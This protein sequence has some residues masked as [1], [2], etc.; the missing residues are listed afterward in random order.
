MQTRKEFIIQFVGL[1]A[2]EHLYEYDID[3]KFFEDRDYSE[4]TESDLQVK[5]YLLKQSSMM[6]L[7]FEISGTVKA[8]CDRCTADFDLPISGNYKLI[9]KVGGSDTGNEDDD[10]ITVPANE[11]QLDISQYLYEYIALSLPI[12]RIHPEDSEGEPTCDKEMLKKLNDFLIE[13]EKE[14]P[15]D[16]RWDGLKDISLN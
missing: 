3:G 9:V 6:V 8:V 12:K 5:L 15:S 14:E 16:P 11:H 13:E 10:I 7:R 4:I 2:G 1:S